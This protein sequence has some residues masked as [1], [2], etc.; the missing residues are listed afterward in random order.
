MC[1]SMEWTYLSDYC[2][3]TCSNNLFLC[4]LILQLFVCLDL[5]TGRQH[6]FHGLLICCVVQL[7]LIQTIDNIIF[8]P[9]TSKK[10][11]AEN[12]SVAKVYLLMAYS[13]WLPLISWRFLKHFFHV[14]HKCFASFRKNFRLYN[15]RCLFFFY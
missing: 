13:L 11:D 7:E 8:F 10:D 3:G 2:A 4:M 9:T 15:F 12:L 6:V 14:S 5:Q 1:P